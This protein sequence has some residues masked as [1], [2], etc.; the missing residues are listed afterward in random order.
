M[1]KA[2]VINQV[3]ASLRLQ[4]DALF[5]SHTSTAACLRNCEALIELLMM[6][7]NLP[8]DAERN[9]HIQFS[10]HRLTVHLTRVARCTSDA[11]SKE[12]ALLHFRNARKLIHTRNL[13]MNA[14]VAVAHAVVR[15]R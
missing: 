1:S 11:V 4:I 6:H 12:H 10:L 15:A 13:A 2:E 8:A 7:T 9:G 14:M 3:V 5:V